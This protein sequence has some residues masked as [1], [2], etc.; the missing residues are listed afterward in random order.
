[1]HGFMPPRCCPVPKL[2]VVGYKGC[3]KPSEW[4]DGGR[5]GWW[6]CYSSFK[7][8]TWAWRASVCL[9]STQ[10][11]WLEMLTKQVTFALVPALQ[12]CTIHGLLQNQMSC[13]FRGMKQPDWWPY[14]SILLQC[15]VLDAATEL[16][17]VRCCK[18]SF[19]DLHICWLNVL[20][21]LSLACVFLVH[22][23]APCRLNPI[24][25]SQIMFCRRTARGCKSWKLV[26]FLGIQWIDIQIYIYIYT[27]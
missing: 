21:C 22:S 11:L 19:W 27:L 10:T 25:S 2:E 9:T 20:V 3:A 24:A 1:M 26:R 17:G 18:I 5:N 6:E 12:N 4:T 14:M 7:N 8:L 13:W 23:H 15:V 16:L